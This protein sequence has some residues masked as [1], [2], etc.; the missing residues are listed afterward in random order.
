M[1]MCCHWATDYHSNICCPSNVGPSFRARR[2]S[3]L[4][5]WRNDP[6]NGSSHRRKSSSNT[7]ISFVAVAAT[8][9]GRKPP[10]QPPHQCRQRKQIPFVPRCPFSAST[11][12]HDAPLLPP[13]AQRSFK[14]LPLSF[15]GWQDSWASY[16]N[17]LVAHVSFVHFKTLILGLTGSQIQCYTALVN[18]SG[19]QLG[20]GRKHKTHKHYIPLSPFKELSIAVTPCQLVGTDKSVSIFFVR[21]KGC[22]NLTR[23]IS[24]IINLEWLCVM[25]VTLHIPGVM[26]Q[27]QWAVQ[28]QSHWPLLIHHLSIKHN[29]QQQDSALL[30]K[31]QKKKKKKKKDVGDQT[32]N[33]PPHYYSFR[34]SASNPKVMFSNLTFSKKP[35]KALKW[36]TKQ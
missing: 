6:L 28:R 31:R 17:A 14:T 13:K 30:H 11:E 7:H 24:G 18:M 15:S 12:V 36:T 10:E 20:V 22:N 2:H 33:D 26:I 8:P 1:V 21:T 5:F 29:Q 4:L 27:S 9:L 35:S 3:V 23:V 34:L 16:E 19:A 25:T 32:W